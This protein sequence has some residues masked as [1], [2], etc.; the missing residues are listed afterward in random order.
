MARALRWVAAGSSQRGT[1]DRRRLLR[2]RSEADSGRRVRD[3]D[4]RQPNPMLAPKSKCSETSCTAACW[5][6][7]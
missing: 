3:R 7:C 4:Q 5:R 1:V 2:H 6:A